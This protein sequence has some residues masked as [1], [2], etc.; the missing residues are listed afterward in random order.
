MHSWHIGIDE[1]GRGPLAGPVAVGVVCVRPDFDWDLIP[2]VN[3]SK[4]LT[5][6]VR[7]EIAHKAAELQRKG[8]LF[9]SVA[10]TDAGRI[11]RYGIVPSVRSAMERA[12]F[13]LMEETGHAPEE[14]FVQLDGLLRA[15]SPYQNQETIVGGDGKEKIIGLASI[16]AKVQR[17]AYMVRI[18]ARPELV[19]YAFERHKGYGTKLHRERIREHG[20]CLLHRKSFCGKLMT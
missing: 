16:L 3:D 2:G 4:K 6:P 14:C 13:R 18:A 1:A 5:A 17:D 7:E 9:A 8:I 10:M 11:D 12:L 19:Q 20:L 15:P